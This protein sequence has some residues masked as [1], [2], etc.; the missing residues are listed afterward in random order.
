MADKVKI[1]R[2]VLLICGSVAAAIAILILLIVVF[3]V[4]VKNRTVDVVADPSVTTSEP[5]ATEF[6]AQLESTRGTRLTNATP[7][8]TSEAREA[9]T[10]AWVIVV[11]GIGG[12]STLI[13]LIATIYVFRWRM[14]RIGEAA[15]LAPDSWAR[16]IEAQGEAI[17]AL[18]IR[19]A[20]IDDLQR[21]VAQ[22]V[23]EKVNEVEESS[24]RLVSRIEDRDRE[25][26]RYKDGYDTQVLKH[27]ALELVRLVESIE[28]TLLVPGA[29]DE[30]VESIYAALLETLRGY[31]VESY[32]PPDGQDIRELG[33]LISNK[34]VREPT[35]NEALNY[36]IMRV[37]K[38]A[39]IFG[40]ASGDDSVEASRILSQA[41]VVIYRYRSS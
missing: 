39:W 29:S 21:Q 9:R 14:I 25:I 12:I 28:E 11:L 7:E 41:D 35:D 22:F 32:S 15:G 1:I 30:V 16:V 19:L 6:E 4:A 37:M 34:L 38:P 23:A 36:R 26:Q 27:H 2:L 40:T 10:N 3:S 18:E 8:V 24:A 33:K 5:V 17:K 13:A 20:K 31:G